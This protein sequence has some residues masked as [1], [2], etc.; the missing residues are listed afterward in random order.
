L[1]KTVVIGL[2][3]MG[4]GIAA[5][6]Q[7]TGQLHCAWNRGRGRGEAVAARCGLALAADIASAVKA[8]DL[9]ITSVSTDDDLREVCARLREH[10]PKGSVLLDTSTVSA[11]TVRALAADLDEVGIHFLD[12][13]VSG[14]R[15]GAEQ[16]SLVMMVGGDADALARTRPALTAFTSRVEH[17]GPLGAGQATKAVNQVMAAGINQAVS[18]ALSFGQSLG[19]DMDKAIELLSGGAASSWFLKARGASMIRHDYAPGFR[20][21]LHH[22]DLK[23]CQAMAAEQ[24]AQLPMVEMTLVHYQRLLE[25]GHGD[26]D[27]SALFRQKQTLFQH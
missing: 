11:G 25:A 20:V 5:N 2:G 19:L 3:A 10:M 18:E 14:G 26:E 13:P 6:L 12:G 8:A 4:A 7:R 9:V 21:A 22:K 16:G 24:H 1:I 23:I 15:E 27:I 17:M